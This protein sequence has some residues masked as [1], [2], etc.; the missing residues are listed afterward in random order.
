MKRTAPLLASAWL[1]PIV[2]QAQPQQFQ[3]KE[4]PARVTIYFPTQTGKLERRIVKGKLYD[5]M[6]T[7]L[8]TYAS[9]VAEESLS[10]LFQH[11][12]SSFPAGTRLTAFPVIKNDVMQVSLSREFF[13][14]GFWK[15]PKQT[16]LIVNAIVK[17]ATENN[18]QSVQPLRVL[19]LIEGKP[20]RNVANID[21]RN[22]L[23]PR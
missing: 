19:L 23:S 10:L 9:V 8:T 18:S 17:T 14:K 5:Q 2:A 21:T 4:V 3:L 6:P 22:P 13:A 11:A 16:S 20:A 7:A 1:V 12:H 15:S